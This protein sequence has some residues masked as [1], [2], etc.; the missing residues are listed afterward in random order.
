MS[1]PAILV[2]FLPPWRS[3]SGLRRFKL[4]ADGRLVPYKAVK[5]RKALSKG[6]KNIDGLLLRPSWPTRRGL[7]LICTSAGT[8]LHALDGQC[9]A[10][11]SNPIDIND[12]TLVMKTAERGL[13]R[14]FSFETS[15]QSLV[16]RD[17]AG[18]L[19][20]PQRKA[21]ETFPDTDFS[22]FARLMMMLEDPALRKTLLA[23]LAK[24]RFKYSHWID[25]QR[26][27]P[28]AGTAP[29]ES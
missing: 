10:P 17:F 23:D 2:Q 11:D 26:L 28:S 1:E 18:R 4:H 16:Y 12:P 22:P 29:L 15:V 14:R 9:I 19:V 6:P 7:A 24:H 25:G 13:Y 21:Y 3:L 8:H 5:P 20:G 27:R